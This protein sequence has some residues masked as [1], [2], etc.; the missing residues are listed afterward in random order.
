MDVRSQRDIELYKM[1]Q[2]GNRQ[3]NTELLEYNRMQ[4]YYNAK[5]IASPYTTLGAF[6]RARRAQSDTYKEISKEWVKE[7]L[8]KSQSDD[9]IINA[10]QVE[11]LEYIPVDTV[12]AADAWLKERG[13]RGGYVDRKVNIDVVNLINKTIDEYQGR[14]RK[15]LLKH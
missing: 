14:S 5:G 13:I 8:T 2:A 12:L 4:E 1:W 10:K 9:T 3:R 15:K 7:P 6:R 11:R